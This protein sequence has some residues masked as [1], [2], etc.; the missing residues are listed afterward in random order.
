IPGLPWSYYG[1]VSGKSLQHVTGQVYSQEP[2]A[3]MVVDA[4]GIE[5]GMKVLDLAAAPG[6]KSTHI[7]SYLNNQGLLVANEIHPKR[8]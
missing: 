7:L 4:A 6:G 2:A 8:A 5:P 1:K 3:Q